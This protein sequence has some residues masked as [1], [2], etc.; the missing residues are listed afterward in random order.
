MVSSV[1]SIDWLTFA[2][3]IMGNMV[4][5][6]RAGKLTIF[7]HLSIRPKVI[8]FVQQQQNVTN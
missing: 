1:D 5:N 4:I 6:K 2:S 3:W 8:N 7:A